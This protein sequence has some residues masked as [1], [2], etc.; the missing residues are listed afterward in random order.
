MVWFKEDLQQGEWNTVK[1]LPGAKY[2]IK[3]FP[4]HPFPIKVLIEW[5][6]P[7]PASVASNVYWNIE[8][9]KN[10]DQIFCHPEL[11]GTT[12][13]GG[14]SAALPLKM[15]WPL[16]DREWVAKLQI[17][18][19]PDH[20]A[21]LMSMRNATHPSK[22][23]RKDVVRIIN[24]GNFDYIT[25]DERNPQEACTVFS[26]STSDYGGVLPKSSTWLWGRRVPAAF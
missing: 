15:P 5:E 14:K 12:E 7:I 19:F 10:W 21:W 9:R 3:C 18:E 2:Y 13:D 6:L 24:G 22:P 17:R 26:L 16:S 25:L 1:S 23:K 20:K 11:V 4:D 8:E